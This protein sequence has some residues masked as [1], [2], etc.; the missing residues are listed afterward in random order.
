MAIRQAR[1]DGEALT[2][3]ARKGF[4]VAVFERQGSELQPVD[5][6]RRVPAVESVSR[7]S[8]APPQVVVVHGPIR[9]ALQDRS[10]VP[11]SANL[12]EGCAVSDTPRPRRTRSELDLLRM[13]SE[14]LPAGHGPPRD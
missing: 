12:H 2:S 14:W 9:A 10:R 6:P 4:G 1:R 8:P 11:I 13:D 7:S 3:A 5:L